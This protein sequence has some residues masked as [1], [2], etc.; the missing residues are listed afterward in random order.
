MAFWCR[1]RSTDIFAISLRALTLN[2]PSWT[3]ACASRFFAA[4]LVALLTI[5]NSPLVDDDTADRLAIVHE[6]E[7]LVDAIERQHV[8]DQVVD[9]DLALHVPVDDLR[10]VGAPPRAAERRALPHAPGDKLERPRLDLLPRARDAD[11]HGHTPAAVAALERLAHD[12]DVADAFKAVIRSAAR[13]LDHFADHVLAFG[14]D[15]VRHAELACQR[16]PG[17]IEIDANN[18]IRAGHPGALHDVEPDAAKAEHHHIRSWFHF[19][20]IDHGA[21][22]GGHAAADVAD[23]VERR[24][25]ANLRQRDFREHAEVGE[26][27]TAHVVMNRFTVE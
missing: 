21:D 19:R 25:V 13:E 4:I 27:G 5:E 11:D 23:L 22:P 2:L 12:L 15:E 8:G 24:V 9:V 3:F 17:R 20:R 1:F 16:L 7:A 10:H 14:I 18:H 26:S 6:I